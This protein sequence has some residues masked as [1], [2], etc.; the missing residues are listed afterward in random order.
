MAEFDLRALASKWLA[1]FREWVDAC[2]AWVKE[3]QEA[4]ARAEALLRDSLTADEY[5]Q[6]QSQGHLDLPS[7]T[8]P[9]RVYRIPANGGRVQVYEEDKLRGELCV[10]PVESVPVPDVVL[11][12]KLLIEG[13]EEE[14]LRE[15]RWIQVVMP[16]LDAPGGLE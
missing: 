11:S 4:Q 6:L 1:P 5:D 12:H 9:G 10:A 7:H 15:A 14:Y 8:R 13:A 3:M 16:F 2:F